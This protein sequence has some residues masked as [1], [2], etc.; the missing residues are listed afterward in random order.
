VVVAPPHGLCLEEVRY[1]AGQGDLAA[2]AELTR[3]F[4]PAPPRPHHDH[5]DFS[6]DRRD[7]PGHNSGDFDWI[8]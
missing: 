3:R 8:E 2:R 1:P 5:R 6:L 7:I 4:R